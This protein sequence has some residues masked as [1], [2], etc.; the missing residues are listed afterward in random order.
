MSSFLV[1]DLT[2]IS[3]SVSSL[4]SSGCGWPA[5]LERE[6]RLALPLAW[7][8][9]LGR[10][11]PEGPAMPRLAATEGLAPRPGRPGYPAMLPLAIVC[12]KVC[13]P[14]HCETWG[15]APT[16]EWDLPME[17]FACGL[18]AVVQCCSIMSNVQLHPC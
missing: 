12:P 8:H 17:R 2:M 16:L 14:Q 18:L 7:L 6:A 5:M 4:W 13:T 3:T 11:S 15:A 9:C 10:D 1:S